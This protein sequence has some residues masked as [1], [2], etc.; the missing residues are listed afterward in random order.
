[1]LKDIVGACRWL[2]TRSQ[3]HAHAAKPPLRTRARPARPKERLMS[4][5]NLLSNNSKDR[6][7]FEQMCAAMRE[8]QEERDR[9]QL[10]IIDLRTSNAR[11]QD[12]DAPVTKAKT[13]VD[14]VAKRLAEVEQRFSAIL[15]LSSTLPSLDL[16]AENLAEN[17]R[18]AEAQLGNVLEDARKFRS[19]YEELSQRVDSA[20][21]LKER[22]GNF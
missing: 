12:L 13:D 14:A 7:L 18:R 21:Q 2:P 15:Q 16:R 5:K 6:E 4:L 19:M 20:L 1:M 10:L 11:L 22:I 9:C 17:Q 8:M 3:P